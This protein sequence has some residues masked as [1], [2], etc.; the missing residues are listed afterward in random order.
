MESYAQN[1]FTSGNKSGPNSG[2]NFTIFFTNND[3]SNFVIV[4]TGVYEVIVTC[5]PDISEREAKML[6]S[7]DNL[8]NQMPL[9]TK[10]QCN[11]EPPE[12]SG[13]RKCFTYVICPEKNNSSMLGR[14]LLDHINKAM[15]RT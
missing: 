3:S 11:D 9:P 10:P 2:F 1:L 14:W 4:F 7:S 6:V 5:D 15:D 13:F 12:I 8:P